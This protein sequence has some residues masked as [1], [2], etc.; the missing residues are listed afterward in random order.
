MF[1]QKGIDLTKKDIVSVIHTG[2]VEQPPVA[3]S[4]IEAVKRELEIV[5][6]ACYVQSY[7]RM[8]IPDEPEGGRFFRFPFRKVK[9]L[10][11]EHPEFERRMELTIYLDAPLKS[12]RQQM[13]RMV[14]KQMIALFLQTL[15]EHGI[16]VPYP[17]LLTNAEFE[18]YGFNG[19]RP[20][21][22][23]NGVIVQP[24]EPVPERYDLT[25][26]S[27]PG[28]VFWNVY[29]DSCGG[30]QCYLR[31]RKEYPSIR[32]Y[33]Q[34]DKA[35]EQETIW[36]CFSFRWEIEQFLSRPDAAEIR[37]DCLKIIARH[38]PWGFVTN[39][40]YHPILK[41]WNELSEDTQLCLLRG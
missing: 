8:V 19:K 9:P 10:L 20:E 33:C 6:V 22:R 31:E 39:A 37:A 2:R 7:E 40:N 26:D 35:Q 23:D 5:V 24:V 12:C 1:F 13:T 41:V 18:A 21:E 14:K 17:R 25:Y 15:A 11:P 34:W 4:F 32:V 29:S 3:S 30:I 36:L 28:L 38:D 16:T 27:F